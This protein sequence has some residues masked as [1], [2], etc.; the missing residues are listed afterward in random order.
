MISMS[1]TDISAFVQELPADVTFDVE[2]DH[3]GCNS[4][5]G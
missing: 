5:V 2:L 4:T 1:G 3:I